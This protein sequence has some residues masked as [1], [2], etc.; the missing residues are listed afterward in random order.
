MPEAISALAGAEA[1]A[2]PPK[3]SGQIQRLANKKLPKQKPE[4]MLRLFQY[5]FG[6]YQHAGAKHQLWRKMRPH[7]GRLGF[8]AKENGFIANKTIAR[9][10][11]NCT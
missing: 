5:C 4:C 11:E 3:N 7:N 10:W 8:F 6:K 9:L 1:K 2:M